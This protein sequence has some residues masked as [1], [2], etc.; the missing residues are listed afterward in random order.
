MEYF[1]YILFIMFSF[2]FVIIGGNELKFCKCG[3]YVCFFK[4]KVYCGFVWYDKVV[5]LFFFVW[6]L[7][8]VVFYICINNLYWY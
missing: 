5:N 1:V 6:N 4:F 3:I 2:W 7:N 8:D